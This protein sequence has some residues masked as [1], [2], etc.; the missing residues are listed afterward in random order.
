METL[1]LKELIHTVRQELIDSEN[2]RKSKGLDP[3]FKVDNLKIE[4][5]FV[6]EKTKKTGGKLGIK[7]IDI[8]HDVTYS[9]QQVHKIV[10]ELKTCELEDVDSGLE[11]G[12][13]PIPP[14]KIKTRSGLP[15]GGLPGSRPGIVPRINI[16]GMRPGFTPDAMPGKTRGKTKE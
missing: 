6:V 5:N 7:I 14:E 8:G 15:W 12:V 1:N 11:P 9:S 10:L 4:V 16:P 2:E 13:F 3:L